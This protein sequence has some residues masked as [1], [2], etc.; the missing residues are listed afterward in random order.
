MPSLLQDDQGCTPDQAIHWA[1]FLQ[2]QQRC[3]LFIDDINIASAALNAAM[4]ERFQQEVI[5]SINSI[6]LSLVD[7]IDRKEVAYISLARLVEE[8]DYLADG[9][10]LGLTNGLSSL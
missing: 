1:V 3:V 5:L 6:G 8:T 2:N 10:T 7:D 9:L 4:L